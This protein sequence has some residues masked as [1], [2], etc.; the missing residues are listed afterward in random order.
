MFAFI[1]VDLDQVEITGDDLGCGEACTP[2]LGITTFH[3]GSDQSPTFENGTYEASS[4]DWTM[5]ID[6]YQHILD[7]WY[8]DI[9]ELLDS[10]HPVDVGEGLPAFNLR[11]PLRWATDLEIP[12]QMAV[13]Y[14]S[15]VVFRGC[16]GPNV[17][18]SPS[19]SVQVIPADEVYFPAPPWDDSRVVVV[20]DLP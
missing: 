15:F 2:V 13:S 20:S 1:V 12:N 19:G 7:A 16:D 9:S 6:V 11:P 3:H 17:G 8:G 5:V 10:I 4:G 14:G 18:C